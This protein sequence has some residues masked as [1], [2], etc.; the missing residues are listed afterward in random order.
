MIEE[1]KK[2]IKIIRPKMK[3]ISIIKKDI[4]HL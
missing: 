3:N 2:I 1:E 4:K